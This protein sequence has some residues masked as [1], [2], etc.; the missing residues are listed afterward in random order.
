MVSIKG[1]QWC[2]I[3]CNAYRFGDSLPLQGDGALQASTCSTHTIGILVV[4]PGPFTIRLFIHCTQEMADAKNFTRALAC[5]SVRAAVVETL[6]NLSLTLTHHW[7]SPPISKPRYSLGLLVILFQERYIQE[8]DKFS[9]LDWHQ[10]FTPHIQLSD[11]E[12]ASALEYLVL[13]HLVMCHLSYVTQSRHYCCLRQHFNS[14]KML[15]IP[16]EIGSS[17]TRSN[18]LPN[19]NKRALQVLFVI[20]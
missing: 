2:H 3:L 14:I 7:H 13:L 4:E 19:C 6:T 20:T 9:Y 18:K 12:T 11:S 10:D 5:Q 8:E 15:R 17:A 1:L 16:Q